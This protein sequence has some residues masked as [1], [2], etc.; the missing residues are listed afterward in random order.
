M[1]IFKTKVH[2][3]SLIF[4]LNLILVNS[5]WF[6]P[7]VDI[8]IINALPIKSK[9]LT[10]HCQSHDNDL[11]NKTLYTNE[12]FH[13]TFRRLF[14][15]ETLFFCHF[16]WNSKQKLFDVYN[17]AIGDSCG[18]AGH[19]RYECYW[20]VQEDGFYLGAHRNPVAAYWKKYDW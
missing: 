12:E 9:P 20:R 2:S 10:L 7:R 18:D 6:N 19:N 15:G 4:F 8:Y 5:S 1:T 16:W 17:Y 13:F 11:G 3:F 14:V